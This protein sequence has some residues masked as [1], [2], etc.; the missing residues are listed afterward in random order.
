MP[1]VVVPNA[2]AAHHDHVTLDVPERQVLQAYRDDIFMHHA[3]VLLIHIMNAVWIVATPTMDVYQEDFVGE[4][5]LPLSR[6]SCFPLAERPFFTFPIL[7]EDEMTG[8]R[9]RAAG[10]AA[11]LGVAA[12]AIPN[13]VAMGFKWIFADPSI[14]E[15]GT[16]V[17]TELIDQGEPNTVIRDSHAL[18]SRPTPA[19]ATKRLWTVAERVADGGLAQWTSE[20]R[21]GGGRDPRLAAV[22]FD[23]SKPRPLFRDA[24]M[25]MDKQAKAD[26]T[27]FSGPSAMVEL[28]NG[29][30]QTGLEP[31]GYHAS[32]ERTS[33]VGAK[34][35]IC[36]EHLSLWMLIW[37]L[38]VVDRL[39]IFLNTAAEHAARRILQIQKAVKKNPA[40][41]DFTGLEVYSQHLGDTGGAITTAAFDAHVATTQKAEAF[42][43]KQTRIARE[44][45]AALAAAKNKNKKNGE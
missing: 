25:G 37:Y 5:V 4:E 8:L 12:A 26:G 1:P 41:P 45:E 16:E 23:S 13:A 19:D 34:S 6:A 40:S 17:P 20:K 32:W 10:L 35:A 28:A 21:E 44:E 38:A 27:V 33:G 29:L 18:I 9:R 15:F 24:V 22:A 11:V 30:I 39:D 31:P 14:T 43:L 36:R 7:T 3:R 42:F 2:P